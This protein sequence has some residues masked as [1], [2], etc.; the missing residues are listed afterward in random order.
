MDDMLAAF[1]SRFQRCAP[2]RED[3]LLLSDLEEQVRPV[4]DA[5]SD[6]K[7]EAHGEPDHEALALLTLLSRHAG[8]LGATPSAAHGLGRAIEA[9]LL[10]GETGH[11]A[12]A[13]EQLFL[14]ILEGYTAGREER[15][16]RDHKRAAVKALH[17]L[18]L[19]PH[20]ALLVLLG[21]LDAD[22]LA[23]RVEELERELLRRDL[24]VL[25]L[26]VSGLTFAGDEVPRLVLGLLATARSLGCH[27]VCVGWAEHDP[28]SWPLPSAEL[29]RAPSF[30]EGL[31]RALSQ[32]GVELKTR[33]RWTRPLF[34]R[35]TSTRDRKPA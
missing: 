13:I 20:A 35:A 2:F 14:V 6:P 33:R 32:V 12:D 3:L 15:V 23:P 5:L 17:L 28:Q 8:L 22:E 19:A 9:G 16:T 1:R 11:G 4:F 34:G 10:A 18:P 27:A 7:P 25:L 29:E 30:E 21:E 24:Q 26:D 31:S